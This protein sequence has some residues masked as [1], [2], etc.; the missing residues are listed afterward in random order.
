MPVRC[1]ITDEGEPS[2]YN[3]GGNFYN[4]NNNYHRHN[5]NNQNVVN[6]KSNRN[7]FNHFSRFTS[8]DTGSNSTEYDEDRIF[9]EDETDEGRDDDNEDVIYNE[10]V[11]YNNNNNRGENEDDGE[12]GGS[13]NNESG[14]YENNGE[15]DNDTDNDGPGA[16]MEQL[17]WLTPSMASIPPDTI[18]FRCENCRIDCTKEEDGGRSRSNYLCTFYYAQ[19]VRGSEFSNKYH[20]TSWRNQ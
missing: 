4:N 3:W 18:N 8:D 17:F 9:F 7:N 14:G 1:T 16:R 19:R 10:R 15:N 12:S 2:D 5:N 20:W 11:I 13:I 6:Y